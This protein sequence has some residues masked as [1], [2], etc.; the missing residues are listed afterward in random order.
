MDVQWDKCEES[1]PV[2]FIRLHKPG[3]KWP[4]D[5]NP[6]AAS[7][8]VAMS[9]ARSLTRHANNAILSHDFTNVFC[10]HWVQSP[11]ESLDSFPKVFLCLPFKPEKIASWGVPS[12]D[13]SSDITKWL[14]NVGKCLGQLALVH[15]DL[16][17]IWHKRHYT[18]NKEDHDK[19]ECDNVSKF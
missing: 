7:E 11:I 16:D 13:V 5:Q 10:L 9:E 2:E 8:F 12:C 6:N 4:A 18:H 19:D 3:R 1:V 14:Q 17:S 15:Q